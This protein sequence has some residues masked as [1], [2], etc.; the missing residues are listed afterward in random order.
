MKGDFDSHKVHDP[1]I[2][3][4][5]GKFYLYYKGEQMGE[6]ITFGGRQIRHGVAIA[7]NPLGPYE[8]SEF[9]PISNSGHEICVWPYEGG[10]GSLIT[11]DGPEKNTI[12]W[13]P[14]GINF[15]IKAVIKG[16]PHSIGLNRSIENADSE[17]F[18]VFEWGLTH[19]YEN[20][21]YQYIQR[22]S[23]KRRTRHV[24]KGADHKTK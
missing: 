3:P 17:P 11:T 1:C 14:D 7:N 19:K 10:I 9:N 21:D 16:A 18:A 5:D 22:F 2:L 12:Q 24:A 6:E 20:S 15:E 8:K 23:G 4:F 13:A